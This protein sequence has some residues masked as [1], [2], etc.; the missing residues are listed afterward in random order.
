MYYTTLT[1]GKLSQS[2]II[3][4]M[5]IAILGGSFDPPHIGHA[6][7]AV[8]IRE[9]LDLDQ[10]WLMPCFIHPFG[11]KLSDANHRL[12]M[13]KCLENTNI[14]VSDFELRNRKV[15]YTI[16]TLD[17]LSKIYKND[18]FYWILSSEDLENFQK[19][20][21][22]QEIIKKHNLIIFP[23]EIQASLK[24]KIK[25]CLK[26]ESIPDNITIISLDKLVTT[27]ISSTIIRERVRKNLAIT[28][29]VPEKI[30][31]FIQTNKLYR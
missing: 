19:W 3:M 12:S 30:E 5:K 27:G 29:M 25:K 11:K 20:K 13:T 24:E 1:S 28:Y 7:A 26:L 4:L 31:Q 21:N 22:W 16:D 17:A 10:I 14:K 2:A 8:Q 9:L 15:S 23:R 6:L 18:T